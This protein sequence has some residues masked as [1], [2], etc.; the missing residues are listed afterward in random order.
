[1]MNIENIKSVGVIGSGTMGS[2]IAELLARAGGYRVTIWDLDDGLVNNGL[3]NIKK[4]L[5]DFFVAKGKMTQEQYNDIVD[6]ITP[7]SNLEQAGKDADF[8]VEAIAEKIEVK[9]DVFAR[10]D[11]AAGPET[12]L[13]T[14]TSWLNISEIAAATK[15]PQQFAGMHFFNPVAVMK[16]V[17]V[18]KGSRT[19]DETAETIRA[20]AFKLGKEPVFCRDF[21]FGFLANRAYRVMRNEAVAMVWEKAGSPAEIDKALKLGYGLPMGP[22]EL[23]DMTGGWKTTYDAEDFAVKELGPEQGRIHPLIRMMVRAGYSGGAGKKGIYAFWEEVL[24]KW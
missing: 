22:L 12:I 23:T 14:N 5:Q 18:V 20:L 19:S 8:I 11:A 9:K 13:T 17:E 1:M 4:R 6:R 2:Q 16:L 7:T 21:S 10:L 24:S 15:R 3:N